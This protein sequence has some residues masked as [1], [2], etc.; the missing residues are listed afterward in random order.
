VDEEPTST[1]GS[2]ETETETAVRPRLTLS[3]SAPAAAD[4]SGPGAPARTS[5]SCSLSARGIVCGRAEGRGLAPAAGVRG[6]SSCIFFTHDP[7]AAGR[8]RLARAGHARTAGRI[9]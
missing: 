9:S 8:G 6:P 5:S 7:S 3:D 2:K 1:G 4:R